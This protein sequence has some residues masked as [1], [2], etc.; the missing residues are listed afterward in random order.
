MGPMAT[1]LSWSAC[2]PPCKG[3]SR[4]HLVQATMR[5]LSTNICKRIYTKLNG[6]TKANATVQS[7]EAKLC[8]QIELR[9][10]GLRTTQTGPKYTSELAR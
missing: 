5:Q 3:T 10:A 1:D 2:T 7:A 4:G 6:K 9:G 8:E